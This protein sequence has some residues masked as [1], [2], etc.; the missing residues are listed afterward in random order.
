MVKTCK[1]CKDTYEY[2]GHCAIKHIPYKQQGMCSNECYEISNI[3]QRYRGN[4]ITADEAAISLEVCGAG[5][6]QLQPK[7]EMYYQD[8]LD[9]V[10]QPDI[11]EEVVLEE[12]N[13]EVVI[14]NDEDTTTSYEE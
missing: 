6:K 1:V 3:I 14:L 9:K 4:C 13:V 2:C 12:E 7:I 8:I 10:T 5:N 11:S